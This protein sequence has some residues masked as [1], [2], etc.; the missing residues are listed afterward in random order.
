[1]VLCASLAACEGGAERAAPPRGAANVVVIMTDDQSEGSLM[2]MPNV[3]RLARHGVVYRES[4]ASFP[5]C[6]PSRATLLTGQYA[7]NHR[8][9]SNE[10]PL[11]G[12]D[13]FLEL[14]GDD[15]LATWLHAAGYRTG[16]VGK[17]LNHYGDDDPS[18]VP[19]GW[20]DWRVS[21]NPFRY[22]GYALNENGERV[23]YGDRPRDYSTDVFTRHAVDFIERADAPAG[24]AVRP[25]FLWLAY[26]APHK[27]GP[28]HAEPGEPEIRRCGDSVVP[29]R[30]DADAFATEP[31]PR[32]ESFDERDVSD[33]PPFV[34]GLPRLS[35]R[36]I[37]AETSR[38]RCRLAS[39]GAVDDGV[40]EVMRAL[41]RSGRLDDT[42]VIFTS[43]NGFLEGQHRLT[44]GQSVETGK[45]L[46]YEE[47]LRVPLVVRGPGFPEG[48]AVDTPV[49][50]VD[51]A[52]TILDAARVDP[53]APPD[54]LPL[55]GSGTPARAVRH[56][57][58]VEGQSCFSVPEGDDRTDFYDRY[59]GVRTGRF[60]YVEH[61]ITRESPRRCDSGRGP[62]EA[63]IG[64]TELYDLRSDPAELR[65]HAG[66]RGFRQVEARLA[67]RLDALRDCSGAA[68]R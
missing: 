37:R 58:L 65:N 39:L 16:L 51:L 29:A 14:H 3:R 9:L 47:A 33:K 40:G 26:V 28:R 13:R 12:A 66:D 60:L 61:Q 48:R 44:T 11:G 49:A 43:D 30:R 63:S 53:P 22:Y 2:A 15:N 56:D 42:L 59:E 6:C 18:F 64:A 46:P 54:G 27:G 32:S 4:I 8:V 24:E 19:E 21:L 10:P 36:Q 5:L 17:F 50:N 35:G 7:H 57:V 25:F 45:I 34:S 20:D 31:L 52:P 67:G 62:G 41:R 68:C 55:P 23:R 1:M 38:Y